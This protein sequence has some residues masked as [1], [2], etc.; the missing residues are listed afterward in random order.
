MVGHCNLWLEKTFI[1]DD[2]SMATEKNHESRMKCEK[3]FSVGIHSMAAVIYMMAGHLSRTEEQICKVLD[4]KTSCLDEKAPDEVL[5]GR[6]GYLFCLLFLKKYLPKEVVDRLELSKAARQVFEK[7]IAQGKG[8]NVS[9][10][11]EAK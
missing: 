9:D 7:L 5:F 8:K 2:F 1:S 4:L 10:S 3:S 6:A 11:S